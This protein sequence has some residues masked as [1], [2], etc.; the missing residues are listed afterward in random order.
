MVRAARELY[1]DLGSFIAHLD[2]ATAL[3]M[4][5]EQVWEGARFGRLWPKADVERFQVRGGKA[6]FA[7]VEK[8]P[9]RSTVG[10]EPAILQ[11]I[12]IKAVRSVQDTNRLLRGRALGRLALRLVTGEISAVQAMP[13]V[14]AERGD[15]EVKLADLRRAMALKTSDS[16][17][18]TRS[19]STRWRAVYYLLAFNVDVFPVPDSRRGLR[20]DVQEL[21]EGL[22]R[23]SLEV[24]PWPLPSEVKCDR[25]S[26]G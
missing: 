23:S 15:N 17:G 11:A 2:K 6:W 13:H 24:R 21:Y 1:R 20:G 12:R 18:R 25:E 26:E 7:H 22:K 14:R 4:T 19:E 3:G 16:G 10:R 9:T 5:D 8:S